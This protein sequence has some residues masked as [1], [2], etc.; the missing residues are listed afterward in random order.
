MY[1]EFSEWIFRHSRAAQ[2]FMDSSRVGI[3][4]HCTQ[5]KALEAPH[6]QPVPDQILPTL[7]KCLETLVDIFHTPKRPFWADRSQDFWLS[8]WC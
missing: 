8:G 7:R 4:R 2:P 5:I 3:R 1:I 6:A